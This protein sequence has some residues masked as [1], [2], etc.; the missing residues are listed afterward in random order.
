MYSAWKAAALPLCYT[1]EPGCPCHKQP[2]MVNTRRAGCSA[3]EY[4]GNAGGR[5]GGYG[6]ELIERALPYQL[7]ARTSYAFEAD[8]VHCT[9]V[10][11]VPP[12]DIET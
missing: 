12:E 9:I 6:R 4:G 3:R 8:G 2:E 7:G 1:R 10:L 5:G 11:P